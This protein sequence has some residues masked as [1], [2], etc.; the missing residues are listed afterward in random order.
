[1]PAMKRNKTKHNKN[2]QTDPLIIPKQEI[3]YQEL[4]S[5]DEIGT[6]QSVL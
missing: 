1:M 3:R 5:Y 6:K 2:F 4:L